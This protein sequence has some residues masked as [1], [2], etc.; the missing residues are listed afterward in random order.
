MHRSAIRRTVFTAAVGLGW[1]IWL[2]LWWAFWSDDFTIAQKFAVAIISLMVMGGL[3]ATVW[4]PF[5]M[6]WAPEKERRQWED[7]GFTWRVVATAL[8]FFALAIF[9]VYMLFFP[10]KDFDLC[11]SLV[12]III[13][14]IAGGV[15]M[16]PLWMRWGMRRSFTSEGVIL[17]GVAKEVSEAVEENVDESNNEKND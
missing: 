8:V 15:M 1:F 17:D 12:V 14:V 10:W 3:M 11:Q 16:A 9:C 6:Q 13:V 7:K 4:I 2:L 5:S